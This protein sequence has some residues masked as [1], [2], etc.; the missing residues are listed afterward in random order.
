[1]ATEQTDKNSSKTTRPTPPHAREHERARKTL[2]TSETRWDGHSVL[3]WAPR[4]A[5]ATVQLRALRVDK[6]VWPMDSE[7][8]AR[9][10]HKNHE[11]S[12][13]KRRACGCPEAV[14][15]F[16]FLFLRE[17]IHC[18]KN[19]IIAIAENLALHY[20]RTLVQLVPH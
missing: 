4:T 5:I 8:A 9:S 12:T 16:V 19:L 10:Q 14:H 7:A 6:R 17:C 18:I 20:L 13:Q 1:M 2:S 3:A 15:G 11:N